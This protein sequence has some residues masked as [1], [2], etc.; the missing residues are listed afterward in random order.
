MREMTENSII[1]MVSNNT[2]NNLK[3][4]FKKITPGTVRSYVVFHALNL[5][6]SETFLNNF[7]VL[8]TKK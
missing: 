1:R 3:V 4:V 2:I 5:L 8:L 6:D 7:K